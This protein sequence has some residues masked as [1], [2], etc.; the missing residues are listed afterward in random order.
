M[1]HSRQKCASRIRFHSGAYLLCAASMCR[2]SHRVSVYPPKCY[3]QKHTVKK[4][5]VKATQSFEAE[6]CWLGVCGKRSRT[7]RAP[8]SVHR[9]TKTE[10]SG[11]PDADTADAWHTDD[12]HQHD[13]PEDP[14][15]DPARLP[16]IRRLV[17][18]SWDGT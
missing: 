5:E 16:T 11:E 8:S 3:K 12:E 14:S 2:P 15:N 1:T 7:W 6:Q 17:N 10:P 4:S 9:L 13:E 18:F